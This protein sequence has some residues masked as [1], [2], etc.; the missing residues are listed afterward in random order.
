MKTIL[1]VL[2]IINNLMEDANIINLGLLSQEVVL[3]FFQ[4]RIS[5]DVQPMAMVEPSPFPIKHQAHS[6]SHAAHFILALAL[7]QEVMTG[8]EVALSMLIIFL[9]SQYSLHHL[10]HVH[11]I[12]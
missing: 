5:S 7:H 10:S 11:A 4:I 12:V 9:K 8:T 1:L 2:K 3:L 6:Q